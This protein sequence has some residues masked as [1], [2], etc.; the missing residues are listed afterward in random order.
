[1]KKFLLFIIMFSL[2]TC[3]IAGPPI[4]VPTEDPCLLDP[5]ISIETAY[6]ST[7]PN[8]FKCLKLDIFYSTKDMQNPRLSLRVNT[9]PG[10]GISDPLPPD[11]IGSTTHDWVLHPLWDGT[12]IILTPAIVQ[13]KKV[14]VI[15]DSFTYPQNMVPPAP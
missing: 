14:V 8:G 9:C 5:F 11:Q 1:M 2:G 13:D 12:P 4:P 6:L 15:G 7:T 3:V 10:W